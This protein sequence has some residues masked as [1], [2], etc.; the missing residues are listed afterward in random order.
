MNMVK[1]KMGMVKL[2][3]RMGTATMR[4][5]KMVK[6]KIVKMEKMVFCRPAESSL[7]ACPLACLPTR[8]STCL[9]PRLFVATPYTC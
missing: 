5:V 3:K 9:L 1:M 2:E 4:M 7:S 8:P 6:M